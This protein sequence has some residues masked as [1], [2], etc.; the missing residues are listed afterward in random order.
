MKK[1][2][3]ITFYDPNIKKPP[4]KTIDL[5]S[6]VIYEPEN[7]SDDGGVDFANGLRSSC[8]NKGYDFKFYCMSSRKD[9]DYEVV[10]V[11]PSNIPDKIIRKLKLDKIEKI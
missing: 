3:I 5:D 10:V 9:W 7:S 8:K 11:Q 1:K 2:C 4:Y 6:F